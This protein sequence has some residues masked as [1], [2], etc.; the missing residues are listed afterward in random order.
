MAKKTL[1]ISHSDSPNDGR[2]ASRLA[3]RGFPLEWRR[4]F[5]ALVPSN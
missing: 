5:A 4:P 1:H 3:A 2:T